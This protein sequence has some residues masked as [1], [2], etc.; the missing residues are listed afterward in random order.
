MMLV[1]SRE[2]MAR[3]APQDSEPGA[4]VE[5]RE[6]FRRGETAFAHADYTVALAEFERTFRLVPHDAVRFNIAVCLEHLQRYREART[7]YQ[8]ASE[9]TALSEKDR[10]RAA[11]SMARLQH[12]LGT[13]I[14]NGTLG[15]PVV[16]D[17]EMRCTIPCRMDLDPRAYEVSL[18]GSPART[19]RIEREAEL[20]LVWPERAAAE[21]ASSSGSNPGTGIARTTGPNWLTWTG[22]ALAAAGLGGTI[23]FGLRAKG[24]HDDYLARPTSSDYDQGVAARTLTNVSIGVLCLG[25]ALVAVDLL[26]LSPRARPTAGT[27]TAR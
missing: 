6:A 11:E 16:V 19:V 20:T 22:S 21:N 18:G 9:S 17:R 10:A 12:E 3:A 25:A 13:L 5:A 2:T 24:L 8:A 1:L 14:V 23:G 27:R 7:Q 4:R 15:A 26:F